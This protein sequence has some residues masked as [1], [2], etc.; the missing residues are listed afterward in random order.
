MAVGINIKLYD[1]I[2]L[3]ISIKFSTLLTNSQIL[4]LLQHF[5]LQ[6]TN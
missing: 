1:R 5:C 2:I 3:N 6:I 4:L